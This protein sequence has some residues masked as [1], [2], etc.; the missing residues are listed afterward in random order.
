MHIIVGLEAGGAETMLRRLIENSDQKKNQ[1]VS[2][3]AIGSLGRELVA[4]GY[5]V[6]ALEMGPTS[7][8]RGCYRLWKI[9]RQSH[10]DVIQTWM[11]HSDL[12]GGLIG[13][14]A[15]VRNIVW[16]VR[17]TQIPQQSFS[18]TG[19]VVRLC[20]LLSHFIPRS[21]I[22]CAHSGLKTHMALGYNRKRM[23]VIPNGYD[24]KAW[25]LPSKSKSDIRLEYGLPLDV[26]IVGIV[27]RFDPLKGY[28]YFIEAAGFVAAQSSK[29][30]I[31]VMVGRNVD[32]HNV[33]LQSM[34]TSKG[35]EAKFILMGERKDV[36]SIMYALD[37]LC[38]SSKA[39]GF[40]NVVAE[41]MLMQVPCVVTDVGDAAQIVG[42]TGKVVPPCE[43]HALAEAILEFEDM[44]SY[45]RHEMGVAARQ[46]IVANYD[47][48]VVAQHYSE[49][50]EWKDKK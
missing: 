41:S 38:L 43:P 8:C 40:P 25:S 32:E 35:A 24:L 3:T 6:H 13:R 9:I 23:V 37:V 47:I 44:G 46:R 20:A 49:L 27:G 39:E 36:S 30:Y 34:I 48:K 5:A 18:V 12:L 33:Y 7:F 19:F 21:I 15:G 2:L 14:L 11:Y 28:D 31:F 22:C 45:K 10:P 26:M 50:Y 42:N 16:N 1:I 4:N 17:N 29:Q